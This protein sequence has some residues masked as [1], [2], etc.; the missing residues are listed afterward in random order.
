MLF[1]YKSCLPTDLPTGG[2]HLVASFIFLSGLRS[3]ISILY[4]IL[5]M[6]RHRLLWWQLAHNAYALPP[7]YRRTLRS[8]V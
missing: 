7:H 4:I 2:Q 3:Y 8:V 1:F 6:H 5:T